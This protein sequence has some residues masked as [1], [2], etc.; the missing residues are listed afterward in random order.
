MNTSQ[1]NAGQTGKTFPVGI[2]SIVTITPSAISGGT[3]YIEYTL[4][5]PADV[6]NGLGTFVQWPL[7]AVS[8]TTSKTALYVIQARAVCTSG[9]ILATFGD[10]TNSFTLNS[11]V[12]DANEVSYT[13]DA[14]GTF[15]GIGGPAG[16]AAPTPAML[17]ANRPAATAA[18][19]G[20]QARFTDVGGNLGT[21]GGNFYFSN[22]TRW[23]PM[24]GSIVLDSVDTANAGIANTAEQ[25]LN[26]N[27][28][29]IPAAV[30][31]D[32]DRLRLWVSMSKSSTIDSTTIRIRFGP[33]GTVADPILSTVTTLATTN[34]SLGFLTE[35]KRQNSTTMQKQGN[36]STDVSYNG[37]N[38]GAY[39]VG[40]TVSDMN[41]NGMYLS[42]TSQLT[43]GTEI[44][45]LQDYT[46]E[47]YAT[48]S[49]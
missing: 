16:V 49:L 25:Q 29:I 23:K 48:D 44:V 6:L 2:G 1:L 11:I 42:I 45:T 47:L 33:L 41:L 19:V 9:T 27:H 35:F 20:R 38:A 24:N 36:A 37:A 14:S 5:P 40:V 46:L 30:I 18:N 17:W 21:G 31:G 34:Q 15:L 43:G 8:A 32:F 3:G 10:P 13:Y 12:W 7:G 26:P 22:G 4:S 39:P 28:I